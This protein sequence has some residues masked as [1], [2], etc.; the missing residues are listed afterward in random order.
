MIKIGIENAESPQAGELIRLLLNHPDVELTQASCPDR[1]GALVSETHHGLIAEKPL[2]FCGE[3]DISSLDLIFIFNGLKHD[4][5]LTSLL[6]AKP[7]G[8]NQ[9]DDEEESPLPALIFVSPS[10]D[11]LESSSPYALLCEDDEEDDAS[12]DDLKRTTEVRK[13]NDTL[14]YGVPEINRKPLVRGARAAVVP[15]V[16]ESI[17]A[18]VLAPLAVHNCLP[19]E[20]T[21]SLSG[22]ADLIADFSHRI[23]SLEN[24]L[25]VI[26]R[27]LSGKN[28]KVT[29]ELSR[30]EASRGMRLGIEL[31]EGVSSESVADAYRLEY[32]DH[33]MAYLAD[34]PLDLK[35]VEGTNNCIISVFDNEQGNLMVEAIADARM[36]GGAG[37]AL[38]VM[39]LLTGLYEK[40]GLQLKVSSF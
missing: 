8:Q 26:S 34:R 13:W 38:H 18:I 1:R 23:E 4:P 14:I 9:N 7:S 40:T 37:Q 35:E 39:N 3:L 31:P 21:I 33:N 29:L 30:S 20:I 27:V 36:R 22:P 5:R 32:D 24:R 16:A 19:P 28:V 12:D 2:K 15:T 11:L 17:A 25:N 10:D 6:A